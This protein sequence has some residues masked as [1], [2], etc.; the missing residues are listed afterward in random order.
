MKKQINK[1]RKAT[2]SLLLTAAITLSLLPIWGITIPAAY[3][4]SDVPGA[5]NVSSY[6]D[7]T[8]RALGFTVHTND[9]AEQVAGGS[10]PTKTDPFALK[11][12][13]ELAIYA[14]ATSNRVYSVS[15]TEPEFDWVPVEA[16]FTAMQSADL[17][18]ANAACSVAFDP[19]GS[20]RKD[21]VALLTAFNTSSNNNNWSELYLHIYNGETGEVAILNQYVSRYPFHLS[22]ATAGAFLAIAA[23]D[24]N[25]GDGGRE[26]LAVYTPG[27][28][29]DPYVVIYVFDP[30]NNTLT[31]APEVIDEIRIPDEGYEFEGPLDGYTGNYRIQCHVRLIVNKN[32]AHRVSVEYPEDVWSEEADAAIVGNELTFTTTITIPLVG[33]VEATIDVELPFTL[34][35]N[36]ETMLVEVSGTG[37]RKITG[38][39]GLASRPGWYGLDPGY[40]GSESEMYEYFSVSLATIPA[41][42]DAP[43]A[44]AVAS[45]YIRGAEK[46]RNKNAAKRKDTFA[47][48]FLGIWYE[49]LGVNTRVTVDPLHESWSRSYNSTENDN[50]ETMLFP[51]VAAGDIN[52]DGKPEVVVAGYRLNAPDYK[53]VNDRR[54]DRDRFLIT[55]YEWDGANFTRA[56]PFQWVSLTDSGDINL[57]SGLHND[58]GLWSRSIYACTPPA[59]TVFSERGPGYSNSVFVGGYVLAL[60]TMSMY[61]DSFD[62]QEV[63]MGRYGGYDNV[64]NSNRMT[65]PVIQDK[66]FR[67]RCNMAL[68][69]LLESSTQHNTP[70]AVAEAV[71]GNFLGDPGGREQVIFTYISEASN[72]GAYSGRYYG[73]VGYYSFKGSPAAS[74]GGSIRDNPM[75]VY[76]TVR[77]FDRSE[78]A[79]LS[80]T[81]PDVNYDSV[82]VKYDWSRA[83]EW[84]FSDPKIMVILQAAPYFSELPYDGAPDTAMTRTDGITESSTHA[85]EISAGITWGLSVAVDVSGG[86]G[87]NIGFESLEFELM[88]GYHFSAGWETETSWTHSVSRTFST[89]ASDSVV[90]TMTPYVRYHYLQW[91]PD[92]G[93]WL[94]MFMDIPMTPRTTQISVDS[95]DRVAAAKGWSTLRDNALGG[96]VAGDPTTYSPTEPPTWNMYDKHQ[97]RDFFENKWLPVG[98]GTG[99]QTMTIHHER[100]S[101]HGVTWG[102]GFHIR[103]SIKVLA[104]KGEVEGA[105][106]YTGGYMWGTFRATDYEGTVPNIPDEYAA[107]Y[108][109]EWQFGAYMIS[110]SDDDISDELA[111]LLQLTD[112][113]KLRKAAEELGLDVLV[114]GYRV[115]GVKRPPFIPEPWLDGV[116]LSSVK[117]VWGSIRGDEAGGSVLR[118]DVARVGSTGNKITIGEVPATGSHAY[119]FTEDDMTPGRLYQY[120][121]QAWGNSGGAVVSG[122]WSSPVYALTLVEEALGAIV[123]QPGDVRLNAGETAEFTVELSGAVKGT[124]IYQWQTLQNGLWANIAG[125]TGSMLTIS[126]VAIEQDGAQYRCKITALVADDVFE[127]N[128]NVAV[129]Y[130]GEVKTKDP[131]APSITTAVLQDGVV[132]MAYSQQLTADGETPVVWSVEN[133]S[134]P[135]GLS[136]SPDGVVSGVP[137]EEGKALLTIKAENSAGA[138]MIELS[139]TVYTI[140]NDTGSNGNGSGPGG[141]SGSSSG[142]G[143]GSG[144]T[145]GTVISDQEVPLSGVISYADELFTLGLFLGYGTDDKGEPVFGLDDTLNRVQALVLTIRLLGL[146]EEALAFEGPHPFTDVFGWQTPY[147]AYAWDAGITKGISATRFGPNSP[148]TC[149]QFTTFILRVL[150]YRDDEGGDFNYAGAIET[151]LGIGIYTDE[152]LIRLSAGAF[153]RGDAVIVMAGAL[154]ANMNN[155]DG[156]LLDALCEAGLFPRETA[157]AFIENVRRIDNTL[158]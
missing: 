149:Q 108:D 133:G 87:V 69:H 131:L 130:V 148:V 36:G 6:D 120:V 142:P 29:F 34:S 66:T 83:P 140:N 17:T 54:L 98:T 25:G 99:S 93:E 124:P 92:D 75:H 119:S 13:P 91:D 89:G 21:Y 62:M 96:S 129:L 57:G 106:D 45:S 15:E 136:L 128:S 144:E 122:M 117:L 118:Y 32:G 61:G 105:I 28:P 137:E 76:S 16:R 139:L 30:D 2:L 18:N 5:E 97:N 24:Y 72:Y 110:L 33:A 74:V 51:S 82:I 102:A 127:I 123:R 4:S 60:P 41:A 100:S 43:D 79:G 31:A 103:G 23:G 85:V 55:Y 107:L 116:T 84:Y 113:D 47:D 90:L 88:A 71:S 56:A 37:R 42:G 40:Y 9:V 150:G 44:L 81:A 59:M 3:A 101:S 135:A 152:I 134:M 52:G 39:G 114:L 68:S 35:S 11:T 153:L 112:Q 73:Y 63:N 86:L 22:A 64:P 157:D 95:Y 78:Q 104:I 109:F 155:S 141:G 58:Y 65:A 27:Y 115:Q 38:A 53:S 125:A 94:P 154:L 156:T 138:D 46:T 8:Y 146:E 50:Y 121:L 48:A 70:R 1:N 12:I 158:L 49:P 20:G 26:E 10:T 147:V 14:G 126:G 77:Y 67:I 19:Y 7:D 151:A 143:G 111:K 145:G 132:G 80:I